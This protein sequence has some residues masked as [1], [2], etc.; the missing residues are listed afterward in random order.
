[1]VGNAHFAP[2]PPRGRPCPSHYEK[3]P[4]TTVIRP[5]IWSRKFRNFWKNKNGTMKSATTNTKT[6][7]ARSWPESTRKPFTQW[8]VYSTT[9]T[10]L[11]LMLQ[12]QH[13]ILRLSKT[14]YRQQTYSHFQTKTRCHFVTQ[15][16]KVTS[17]VMHFQSEKKKLSVHFAAR[18]IALLWSFFH[19]N[20]SVSGF[21][22]L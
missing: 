12:N 5:E 21:V 18:G 1:M 8:H 2:P 7:G 19:L 13:F 10:V 4:S 9:L 6:K 17:H 14:C 20:C 15:S 3:D 11:M 22:H 16:I